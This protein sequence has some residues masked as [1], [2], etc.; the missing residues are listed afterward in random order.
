MMS[1]GLSALLVVYVVLIAPWFGRYRY[2]KFIQKLLAGETTRTKAYKRGLLQQ[3]VLVAVVFLIV[4]SGSL[5]HDALGLAAPNSWVESGE[6][7]AI[8]LL[9][10]AI[11]T[12]VFRYRGDKQFNRL[13]RMAWAILPITA[14][15]RK[16]FAAIAVGAGVSEEILYRGFLYWYLYQVVPR[17]E[18]WEDLLICSVI[19]G[20][21]HLY[22]GR[23]GMIGTAFVGFAFGLLYVGTGSL[24]TPVIVHAAVDLRIIGILSPERRQRLANMDRQALGA[25]LA[26]ESAKAG[27]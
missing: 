14:E 5:T 6:Y 26:G 23:R 15:E 20:L 27:G 22:Q 21:G 12:L 2:R 11:T 25:Q 13:S 7:L 10:I 8:M 18:W 4:Y 3:A 17:L 19:F 9:V 16:W 24:F 1:A